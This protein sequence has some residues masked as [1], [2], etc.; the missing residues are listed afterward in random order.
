MSRLA[1][2]YSL[3]LLA[4]IA[5]P[6]H[7][8]LVNSGVGPFYDGALHLLLSP[9][10]LLGIV[11]LALLAGQ[12]G[13]RAGRLAVAALA[14]AWSLGGMVGLGLEAAIE[15]P[16]LSV[17][18][19]LVPAVLVALD[20]DRLAA[21]AVAM[22]AAVFGLLHGLLNGSALAA[23]GAGLTSLAGIVATGFVAALLLAAFVTT[24][25]RESA[26]VAVRVAGSWVAA[27]GILTL[28]WLAAS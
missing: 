7:A 19:F 14:V 20:T 18:S 24:I 6:A 26:R 17:A 22:L 15:L 10:D 1:L 16:G 3:W 13:I 4:L 28:G 21:P 2:R 25:R 5:A 11:A 27:V 23:T 12:R 8:H 9:G